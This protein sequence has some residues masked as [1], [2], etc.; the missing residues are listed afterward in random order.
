VVTA[1][2][3]LKQLGLSLPKSPSPVANYVPAVRSGDLL[4][5]SGVGPA[6]P[7]GTVVKGK[8]GRDL[9]VDEGYDAAR[10]VGLS[11]L[12]RLKIELGDLDKVGRVVKLLAMVNAT[13]E[14]T[15]HPAVINGCSDLLVEVF[16]DRG[17]HA[18]SAVGMSSLPFDIAVEIEMIVEVSL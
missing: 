7:D 4:F 17:R 5:L 11:L 2:D 8:L 15:E 9:T 10:L 6:Q 14:F 12:A 16:G 3:R 18:R 1:E 13:P